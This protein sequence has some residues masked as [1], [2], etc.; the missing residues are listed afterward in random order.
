MVLS[1]IIH[2][3]CKYTDYYLKFILFSTK[4][5]IFLIV[6][7]TSTRTL[8]MPMPTARFIATSKTHIMLTS[9]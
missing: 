2:L 8:S 1:I 5:I 9:C 6:S 4:N 3:I 7:I